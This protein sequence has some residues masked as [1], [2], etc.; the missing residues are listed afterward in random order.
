MACLSHDRQ[1]VDHFGGF[2][3][4]TRAELGK[5]ELVDV[6]VAFAGDDVE[7]CRCEV[8]DVA[9]LVFWGK[10]FVEASGEQGFVGFGD[11][12]YGQ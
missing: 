4:E 6:V 2:E 7:K 11:E 12:E 3:V 1:G 8:V 10:G 5:V 9:Y